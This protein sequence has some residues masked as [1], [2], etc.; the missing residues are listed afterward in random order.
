MTEAV[1]AG[2]DPALVRDTL[3]AAAEAA[4]GLTLPLFRTGLAVDNKWQVGF[5]P[6]T[7]AD[8]EA[9]TIIR[10]LISQRFPDHG[11]V[12]EEWDD[13][14]ADSPFQWIIDPIDGTRAFI[15][16]VPVWGTL[17]GLAVNG[18]AVAGLMSQPFTGEIWLGMP[19]ESRFMHRDDNRRLATSGTT[20]LATAKLTTT[21]PDL[22]RPDM[23]DTLDQWERVR[24]GAMMVRYGLDSYGYCLLASGQIDLVV[25]AGLKTVDIVPLIPIIENAGGMVT[26]WTGGPAEHGGQIIAA[27]TPELH[28]EALALLAP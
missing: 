13:K 28:G 17:I 12:G 23:T 20:S 27:A 9:E 21:S 5:D 19:G 14:P 11:I 4:A 3:L 22:F 18:R 2:L 10:S 25:E 16:G 26:D 6:V 24:A 15:T 1:F 8:R 7:S